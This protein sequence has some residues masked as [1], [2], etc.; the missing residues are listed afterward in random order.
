VANIIPI[1]K[2]G[3][4]EIISNYRPV[5]L[6]STVSKVFEHMF[7]SRLSNFVNQQ[8]IL[9]QLQFGFR[10]GH[11]THMAVIKL[12]ETIISSLDKGEFAAT[13]FLDFSKAFDTV[14]HSILLEKLNHYG[15]RGIA[16]QWVSSYLTDRKQFC[17]FGGISSNQTSITCGVPQDSILGP[18]LFL[19]YINDLAF[20]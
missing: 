1:F 18:L 20:T 13:I 11:S 19:L 15:V 10:E 17:T 5:S 7:Y 14:N 4:T 9:Y 12:L 6:L 16:N 3:D 2:S 8:K